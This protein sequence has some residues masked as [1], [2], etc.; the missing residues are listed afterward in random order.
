MPTDAVPSPPDAERGASRHT[1]APRVT[2]RARSQ[3]HMLPPGTRVVRPV[4]RRNPRIGM[5]LIIVGTIIPILVGLCGP[6]AVA[7]KLG[8]RRGLLPPWYIPTSWFHLNEWVAVIALWVAIAIGAVGLVIAVRAVRD[9]WR[10][11]VRRLWWT[12]V[13]LNLATS[14]TL[15]LTSADVLM[16][17]AYGRIQ[18]LGLS[19]YSITPA[20][21][22]RMQYDIVLYWTERPWQDTPS[23]YGPIASFVQLLANYLGGQ[24]MHDVVFWL[25]VFCVVPMIIIA[26]I[27]LRM[28]RGNPILQTRAALLTIM[29]PL[30]IWSVVAGAHNE[31]LA[32]VFAIGALALM[33]RSP[34][35]AGILIG[36]AG[37][38]KVNMVFYGIAMLWGYRHEPRRLVQVC[39]GAAIPLV[40]C[41]GLWEPTALFAAA[42]NTSYVNSAAWAAWLFVPLK[43]VVGQ[44]AAKIIVNVVSLAGMAVIAWMLFKVVP[45]RPLPGIEHGVPLH[46]DPM[47]V[48]VRTSMILYVAWLTTT[49][50]SYSWY[51]LLAWVP[52]ALC[53]STV[54]DTVMVWRSMWLSLAFVTGRVIEFSPAVRFV[55]ARVRDTLTPA[56]QILVLVLIVWWW[57]TNRHREVLAPSALT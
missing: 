42:R 1:P 21:I 5:T 22:F 2:A 36:L 49:P 33:R 41:Y 23:V 45:L 52:L 50:N 17:A 44:T 43:L 55:G 11:D 30:M 14:L 15:P 12:G 31:A 3:S 40:L 57:W 46:L 39:V 10:P 38:V 18:R 34:L 35:G 6:S 54:L 20:E 47:T 32:V 28:A 48:A 13:A 51:D 37:A 16:Y 27:V 8:P 24:N 56:A 29:N 26:A 4:W 53:Q 9:G 19:P 7:L 25:Q